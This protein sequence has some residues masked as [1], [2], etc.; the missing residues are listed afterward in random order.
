[1]IKF[2]CQEKNYKKGLSIIFAILRAKKGGKKPPK[3]SLPVFLQAL[4]STAWFLTIAQG[5][6]PK[7]DQTT[8]NWASMIQGAGSLSG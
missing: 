5:E 4:K 2:I 8:W 7:T 6:Q 1:M 3:D